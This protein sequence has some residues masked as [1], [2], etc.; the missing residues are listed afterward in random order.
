MKFAKW[1]FLIAGIWGVLVTTPLY[2][3]E[4]Q[5]GLDYPP[6]LNHPEYYYGF[7]GVTLAWQVAFLIISR[8]P[9]RLRPVML[10]AIIEKFS[11]LAWFVLYFQQR[12]PTI[13]VGFGMVDLVLCILFVIAYLRTADAAV[14]QQKMTY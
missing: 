9:K 1:T 7:A 2:F 5:T 4:T 14:S 3:M 11:A 6:V 8:D 12:I 10:A 13:L